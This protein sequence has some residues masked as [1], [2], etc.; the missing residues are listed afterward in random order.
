MCMDQVDFPKR[1]TSGVAMTAHLTA[2]AG[3]PIVKAG[4]D[5][6]AVIT[7]ALAASNEVLC[8][9]DVLVIAQKIISKAQNRYVRLRDIVPSPRSERLARDVN[10]DPRLVELILRESTEVVRY[11]RDVLVVSHNLGFV[12]AN[13]GID[14]SN[15]EQGPDDDTVLLLPE[16]PDE[17][18]ALLAENLRARTGASVGVIINDSHGRAFRS[19][20]VGVA[21]GAH[22][23]P[24]L[25]DLRGAPDLYGRRLRHTDVGVADEMA[26]AASLLM[27]QADEGR[28]I[29][30]I[31]GIANSVG[32]GT[33]A[34]L[35]RPKS[36]DLFRTV[37][38]I[39][40]DKLIG[41]RRS[42]RRYNETPVADAVIDQLLEAAVSAPSAHN[43]Q[44][45]RFAVIKASRVKL[46]LAQAMADRLRED[47][48][49]D[50]DP[51]DLIEGDVARSIARINGAPVIIVVCLTVKEMDRY[52]DNRRSEA[53][54]QMAVQGTAMAMQNLLLA[55]HALNL[56][57][58]VMCAPLF[59]PDTVRAAL[60]LPDDW[61][62]QALVTL[63]FPADQSQQ[64]PRKPLSDVVRNVDL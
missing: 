37:A 36:V 3:V 39:S 12:L 55:A 28:P 15:V 56:G 8:D 16:D 61:E 2:L 5:L 43:R 25:A 60:A 58:S 32:N 17:T 20:A 9:G 47:R 4:D 35:I 64:R 62:S 30:L 1:S 7:R 23:V 21:I 57:A 24:T 45:W 63:G 38:E 40:P 52:P 50:G 49:R 46:R 14:Q 18:C 22:G 42:I 44:P 59:C 26:S 6:S 33:A 41:M 27:G 53:E 31:R 29:V 51:A 13:A 48:T 10:K 54:H 11:R 19:G 34:D